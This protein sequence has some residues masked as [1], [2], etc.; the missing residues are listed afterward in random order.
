MK[1]L[2]IFQVF[3]VSIGLISCTSN[4]DKHAKIIWEKYSNGTPKVVYEFLNDTSNFNDEYYY[5]EF[6]ENGNQK[7]IGLEKRNVKTGEWKYYHQNGVIQAILY[8]KNDSLIGTQKVF[9]ENGNIIGIDSIT[10]KKKNIADPVVNSFLSE[11][12]S[13]DSSI[14]WFNSLQSVLK[15]SKLLINND[16]K[17][18]TF[19]I[20]ID[21]SNKLFKGCGQHQSLK[22]DRFIIFDETNRLYSDFDIFL[23]PT[24]SIKDCDSLFENL[25]VT[26]RSELWDVFAF[27]INRIPESKL[28]DPYHDLNYKFPGQ[29]EAYVWTKSDSSFVSLGFQTVT[30]FKD[31]LE[32]QEQIIHKYGSF[33]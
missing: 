2:F 22:L 33:K 28:K 9:D 15:T 21:F 27:E 8:F 11:L 13:I 18:D 14:I 5:H 20:H 1:P 26:N 23:I 24:L 7:I 6:F 25:L 10:Y 16:P 12:V 17:I 30:N 4:D 31:V 29:M 19:Y 3:A 32:Y